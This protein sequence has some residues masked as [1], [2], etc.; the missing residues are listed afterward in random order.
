MQG[1]DRLRER[2]RAQQQPTGGTLRAVDKPQARCNVA[3][4]GTRPLS[5]GTTKAGQD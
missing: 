4:C 3:A 2:G 1:L 5:F